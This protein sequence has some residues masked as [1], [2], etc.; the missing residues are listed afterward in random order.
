[1]ANSDQMVLQGVMAIDQV[2]DFLDGND[3][4]L[5]Q[6]PQ[7]ITLDRAKLGNID[8]EQSLSPSY[9]KPQYSVGLPHSIK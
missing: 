2:V 3:F 7:I 6:G 5:Q 8:I 1:M 9:F 4:E